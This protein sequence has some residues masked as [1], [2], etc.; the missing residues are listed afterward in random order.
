MKS[1]FLG[2]NWYSTAR[3][4][5]L[6]YYCGRYRL[7]CA[8][9]AEQGAANMAST[10]PRQHQGASAPFNTSIIPTKTNLYVQKQHT[11]CLA[12][13]GVLQPGKTTQQLAVC[14]AMCA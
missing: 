14:V 12:C 5:I 10:Q 6:A 13:M 4:Y 11:A 9:A 7:S 8:A 1:C 2:L 3:L